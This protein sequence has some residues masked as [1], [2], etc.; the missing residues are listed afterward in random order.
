MVWGIVDWFQIT[1]SDS[2]PYVCVH[3]TPHIVNKIIIIFMEH[4]ANWISDKLII[5]TKIKKMDCFV[6]TDCLVTRECGNYFTS[7]LLFVAGNIINKKS[8]QTQYKPKILTWLK[9]SPV[10]NFQA[11]TKTIAII[12][13]K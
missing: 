9:F 10:S 5:Y 13:S 3:V 8:C 12:L 6:C 4:F 11:L 1:C 7:F 2:Y